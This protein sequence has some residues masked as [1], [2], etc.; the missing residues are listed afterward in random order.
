MAD[1]SKV[2]MST[3]FMMWCQDVCGLY[4]EQSGNQA[5]IDRRL[6]QHLPAPASAAPDCRIR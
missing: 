5:L 6:A 2:C 1:V 4:I 3:G